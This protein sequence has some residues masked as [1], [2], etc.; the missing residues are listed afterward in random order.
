MDN[1]VAL[2]EAYLRVNGYFT[3]AEYPVLEAA[4]EG[5]F[6]TV[7]DLD[8]LAFRFPGAGSSSGAG[9]P[10]DRHVEIDPALGVAV[11]SADMIVGEVKEGRGRLN[12]AA[13]DPEVLKTALLR[14]GCA[15]RSELDGIA[16]QLA[17]T[18]VATLRSGHRLRQLIFASVPDSGEKVAQSI[19]LG[20][21]V[22]F[23]QN[24]LRAHWDALHT[25]QFK[26]PAFGFLATLEKAQRGDGG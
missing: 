9:R 10:G 13:L 1:A 12:R 4:R 19:S 22:R 15:E 6:R 2:V 25:A 3:V 21:V 26:D 18:G 23:L 24:H 5:G 8:I 16:R 20:R 14:F 17:D 7:T 11:G